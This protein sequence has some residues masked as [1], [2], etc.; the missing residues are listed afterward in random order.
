MK[1][2]RKK[3]KNHNKNL[4]MVL[5][6]RGDRNSLHKFRF[7]APSTANPCRDKRIIEK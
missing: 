4:D 2:D 6:E 1:S 5:S 7:G 3:K